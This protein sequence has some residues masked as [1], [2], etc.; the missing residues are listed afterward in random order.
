MKL[1]K[2]CPKKI[3]PIA[4]MTFE[5]L[6][7]ILI[8]IEAVLNSRPFTYS[9]GELSEPVT[10]VMLLTG[11][12]LLNANND[13]LYDVTITDEN[14]DILNKRARYLHKLLIYF[15][16]RWRREYFTSLKE[17]HNCLLTMKV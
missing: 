7:T 10:P 3:L 4:R 1:L 8:E 12:R 15:R 2:H 16:G 14:I 11:K 9:H 13:V 5:E 6:E 17:H